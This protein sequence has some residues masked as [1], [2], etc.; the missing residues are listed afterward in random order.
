MMHDY[1]QMAD[2]LEEADV[3][4]I[5]VSRTSKTPTSIRCAY[6]AYRLRGKSIG[7]RK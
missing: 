6:C 1:G 4:L 3:V 2:D 5:G 7:R